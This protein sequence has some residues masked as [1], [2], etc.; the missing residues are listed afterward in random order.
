MTGITQ[1]TQKLVWLLNESWTVRRKKTKLLFYFKG[2]T[3]SSCFSFL[4]FPLWRSISRWRRSISFLWWSISSSWC[5]FSAA[6]CS[7]S[8]RLIWRK[9]DITQAYFHVEEVE[10]VDKK[11]NFI[12]EVHLLL[13]SLLL[14]H[15]STCL[16]D[17]ASTTTT[18]PG[19]FTQLTQ[20]SGWGSI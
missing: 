5:C 6:S 2:F 19:T 8:L 12:L 3:Q 20:L 13:C 9:T 10:K 1:C 7:F 4:I 15:G 11:L 18:F 14:P 17:R 16:S